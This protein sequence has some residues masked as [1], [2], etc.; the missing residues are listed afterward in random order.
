MSKTKVEAQ[1]LM[2]SKLLARLLTDY[3]AKQVEQWIAS[4]APDT[5]GKARAARELAVYINNRC[6]E[7]LS[8]E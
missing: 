3:Q 4:E 7:I 2:D 6:E 1:Q 8:N 5:R